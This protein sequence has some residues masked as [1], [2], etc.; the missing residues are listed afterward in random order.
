LVT[1][2]IHAEG[3]RI[4]AQLCHVGRMSHPDFHNGELPVAPSA[5]TFEGNI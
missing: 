5:L 3:G 1:Q 2:A 4:F